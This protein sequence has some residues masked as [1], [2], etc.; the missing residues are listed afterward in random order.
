MF[1]LQNRFIYIEKVTNDK[2]FVVDLE[3][4]KRIEFWP[5]LVP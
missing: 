1:P 5:P 3:I 2:N 4:K